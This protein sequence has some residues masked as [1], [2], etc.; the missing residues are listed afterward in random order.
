MITSLMVIAIYWVEYDEHFRH[1][2]QHEIDKTRGRNLLN[3]LRKQ[4][5][6][7]D[8]VVVQTEVKPPSG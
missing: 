3:N 8:Y 7:S 4:S 6:G 1:S 5:L 2:H